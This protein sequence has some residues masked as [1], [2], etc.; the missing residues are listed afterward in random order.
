MILNLR[1]KLATANSIVYGVR[2][3]NSWY[4]VD[5]HGEIWIT[6]KGS[7]C[8]LKPDLLIVHTSFAQLWWISIH[9]LSCFNLFIFYIHYRLLITRD[10]DT[11]LLLYDWLAILKKRYN[12]HSFQL[13]HLQFA[14]CL[15]KDRWNA[16]TYV[17][18]VCIW[19]R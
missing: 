7:K 14:F 13:N 5:L 9:K 1:K 8:V 12:L 6:A 4:T 15:L 18:N 3:R 16:L 19:Y 10:M 17:S 2:M 11:V